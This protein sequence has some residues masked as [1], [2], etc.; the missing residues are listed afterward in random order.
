MSSLEEVD[1]VDEGDSVVG[2]APLSDC[3]ARGILHRAVAVL[4][5]R[6]NGSFVLQRR[7]K[8]DFWNPGLWTISCTG[9]VR[10]GESYPEAAAR[11]LSEELGLSS[12]L[13]PRFKLRL[14]PMKDRLVTEYEWVSFFTTDTNARVTPDPVELAGVKETSI[15]ELRRLIGEGKLTE[16]ARILLQR[17]LE[18][19]PE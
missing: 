9:H 7:S 16:D 14:P 17:Y 3:L 15:T 4:V 8:R 13:T 19:L 1:L 18:S 12:P 5:L 6:S 10:R 2:S 11:E